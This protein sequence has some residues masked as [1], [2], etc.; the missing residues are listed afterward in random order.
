[1]RTEYH[2]NNILPSQKIPNN[3]LLLPQS[4]LPRHSNQDTKESSRI[5]AVPTKLADANL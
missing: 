1:M 5:T 2:L 4:L 3:F